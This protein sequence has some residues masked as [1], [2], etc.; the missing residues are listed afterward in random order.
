MNNPLTWESKDESNIIFT[1][2]ILWM[3]EI[4]EPM[5]TYMNFDSVYTYPS[6]K[7]NKM[8]KIT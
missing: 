8:E 4:K 2:K 3:L 1:G 6:M 7:D 5:H